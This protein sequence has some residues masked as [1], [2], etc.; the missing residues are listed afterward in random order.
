MSDTINRQSLSE[1]FD[2]E[3]TEVQIKTFRDTLDEAKK[4]EDP[5]NILTTIIDKAGKIL[6]IVET[7]M[8]NGS[9][10]GKLAES[11]SNILSVLMQTTNSMVNN[12]SIQV[13][14]EMKQEQL[15]QSNR[16][17]DQRDKEIQIKELYYKNKQLED[18]GNTTNNN[19]IL[20]SRED[21]LRFLENK[22]KEPKKAGENE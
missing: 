5:N 14:D 2:L 13:N 21:I 18:G 19:V 15:S 12:Y 11:A 22:G 9:V 3:D 10:S 7:E 8:A 16:R 17:L 1:E 20:S 4:L 6:D